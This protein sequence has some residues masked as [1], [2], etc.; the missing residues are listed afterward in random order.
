MHTKGQDTAHKRKGAA[1]PPPLK[2]SGLQARMT[3]SYVWVTVV[4]VLLMEILLILAVS[5][6]QPSGSDS[7][8]GL[9]ELGWT[10]LMSSIAVSLCAA[11][12]GGIFGLITTRSLVRRLRALLASVTYVADG[13]YEQRVFV[14]RKDEVGLLEQQFNR[15][16]EQL[17]EGIA[18]R[19]KL[20]EQN[21][22]L[23]ER[24]RISRELHDAV[25][26]DL[27]SV[28]LLAGGLQTA[29]PPD[30]PLQPQIAALSATTT[31]MIREMRALL[32]ELRP[33]PLA[34]LGLTEALKELAAGYSTRLGIAVD[35]EMSPVQLS[36]PAQHA[37]LRISQEAVANSVRHA[38]ATR[39]TLS[40]ADRG[41]HVTLTITDNGRGFHP[42]ESQRQHGLGLHLI[43]ERIQELN[44]TLTLTSA[45]GQGTSLSVCLPL[46]HTSDPG[47]DHR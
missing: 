21:A 13:H 28:R 11:P 34:E 10:L 45:P 31:T 40:L 43:Q 30:S 46:E 15:M 20:A 18:Q 24:S 36:A 25:S 42:A 17:V 14:T 6:L 41:D 26:Q 47:S 44:G 7:P 12:I 19:Q 33:L 8:N 32:I 16:A 39:I 1:L 5:L 9:L 23:A 3:F 37:L 4:C 2:W 27:F 29:L 22:R 35:T 38:N